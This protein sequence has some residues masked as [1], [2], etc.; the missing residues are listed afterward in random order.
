MFAAREIGK[1]LPEAGAIGGIT[2]IVGLLLSW[3]ANMGLKDKL[4]PFWISALV[5]F[6]AGFLGHFA[7]EFY[8][9]E[10]WNAYYCEKNF[11]DENP[12]LIVQ[13]Q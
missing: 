10:N 11:S 7:L 4:S 8:P 9:G 6:G 3:L 12:Q 5:L 13:A 2:L 1:V